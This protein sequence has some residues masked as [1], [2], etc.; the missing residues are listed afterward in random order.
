MVRCVSDHMRVWPLFGA[1]FM[2]IVTVEFA[3]PPLWMLGFRGIPFALAVVVLGLVEPLYWYWFFGWLPRWTNEREEIQQAWKS[4]D[5]FIHRNLND[6]SRIKRF[7]GYVSH[8]LIQRNPIVFTYPVLFGLAFVPIG[9]LFAIVICRKYS[10]RFGFTIHLLAN[11]I[12]LYCYTKGIL[13]LAKT[14]V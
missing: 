6:Q 12:K 7:I 5:Q 9:Y 13:A 14:I 2:L 1:V 10:V 11:S 3:M 4:L 8:T